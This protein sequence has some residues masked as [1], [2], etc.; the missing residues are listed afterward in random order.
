MM[1]PAAQ[2]AD[3]LVG[4]AAVAAA[5]LGTYTQEQVDRIVFAVFKAA[6]GA[7]MDLARLA[8]DETG[9][10]VYEHKIMKNAWA[11]LLVYADI[12]TVR[13]VGELSDD[14]VRGIT[15]IAR[16]KG[17]ILAT[18]P[19]TN[20][21]STAI[22]KT[23]ICLKTRNPIIISP[24]RGGRRCVKETVRLL[25][26]AAVGAGAPADSVQVM[27]QGQTEYVERVM[28]HPQLALILATGTSSIVALAQQSGTPTLGVGPGNVPIYVHHTAD[29]A[30]AARSIVHSKTFDNG[31]ICASEQALVV[32]HDV[33]AHLRPLLEGRG[34]YLCTPEQTTAL[35]AVCFD[36]DN[37]RMRADAVGQAAG[38]LARRAGFTVPDGTALLLAEC[39]GVGPEHPLSHEILMPVLALYRC[40]SYDESYR[41][42]QAVTLRGGVGHTVGLYANDERVVADFARLDAAR[43]LVNSPSTQGAIGGIYNS[44]RPSLSLACGTGAGNMSTDNI[45]TDHLLNIHRVARLRPNHHWLNSR[46]LTLDATIDA[47]E[48]LERYNR[49]DEPLAHSRAAGP[50]AG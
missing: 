45:S 17:P 14:P 35:G 20:P 28:R 26:E 40:D 19:M 27:T 47:E 49:N 10:G 29:V 16:P 44:L 31:T 42:C 36:M 24:H 41:I 5:A 13:T 37:M 34:T 39:S 7:R 25:A 18:V 9:M 33:W 11:S 46:M 22:F 2:Y 1:D 32:E 3:N 38:V 6:Y 12:C 21:T 4:R 50:T 48:M 23:L 30:L 43:I 8:V 15:L